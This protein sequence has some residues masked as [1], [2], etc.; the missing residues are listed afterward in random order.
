MADSKRQSGNVADNGPLCDACTRGQLHQV[1]ELLNKEQHGFERLDLVRALSLACQGGHLDVAQ[2]LVDNKLM[3]TAHEVRDHL[4]LQYACQDTDA[5]CKLPKWLI[6]RFR[7]T[8][9]DVSYDNYA[10]FRHAETIHM[11]MWIAKTFDL[12]AKQVYA[13]N[14]QVLWNACWF[15]NIDTVAW[16]LGVYGFPPTKDLIA[17]Q[18]LAKQLLLAACASPHVGANRVIWFLCGGKDVSWTSSFRANLDPGFQKAWQSGNRTLIDWMSQHFGLHPNWSEA[19]ELG[20]KPTIVPKF[21]SQYLSADKCQAAARVLTH[22]LSRICRDQSVTPDRLVHYA[23]WFASM[24]M[25]T[26]GRNICMQLCMHHC[27]SHE[28]AITT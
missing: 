14:A 25:R 28:I 20:K 26:R 19:A 22:G 7:L 27:L 12:T 15:A 8:R 16:L 23:G 24:C 3:I 1:Q 4:V 13:E 11:R 9:D 6:E 17:R 10:C 2:W 18:V 5:E 21:M